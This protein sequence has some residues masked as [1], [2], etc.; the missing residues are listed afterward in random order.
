MAFDLNAQGITFYGAGF[1]G[2]IV[3]DVDFPSPM[4]PDNALRTIE[5]TALRYAQF[6]LTPTQQWVP[7]GNAAGIA[8]TG[9]L[10]TANAGLGFTGTWNANPL[11]DVAV[12]FDKAAGVLNDTKTQAG[13][14]IAALWKEGRDTAGSFN[15]GLR[16]DIGA[17]VPIVVAVSVGIVALAC[18]YVYTLRKIP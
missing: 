15:E 11:N 12:A 14:G 6:A 17:A 5:S 7:A 10:A 18:A 2:Q 13:Q 3:A 1:S 4:G 16:K 8:P 9:I